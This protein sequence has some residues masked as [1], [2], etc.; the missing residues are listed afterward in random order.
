MANASLLFSQPLRGVKRRELN[1]EY[2]IARC[3]DFLF[4]AEMPS[5]TGARSCVAPGRTDYYVNLT[6][7][8]FYPHH[9][10]K[11]ESV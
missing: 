4:Q 3:A 8:H 7:S 10:T 6:A 9:R 11:S 5:N 2:A 1:P